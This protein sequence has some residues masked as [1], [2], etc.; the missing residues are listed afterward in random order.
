M[1]C[2]LKIFLTLSFA[3]DVLGFETL[4]IKLAV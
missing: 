2:G 1:N 4:I 3:S